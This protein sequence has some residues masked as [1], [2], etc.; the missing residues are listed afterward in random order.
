MALGRVLREI[1]PGFSFSIL[2][3][4]RGM[5]VSGGT[6]S[7]GFYRTGA[8]T[9]ASLATVGTTRVKSGPGHWSDR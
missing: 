5:S 3:A 1:F 2:A 9:G 8:T 6:S 7:G 4:E